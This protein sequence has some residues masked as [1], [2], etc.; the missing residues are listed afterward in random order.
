LVEALVLLRQ[1]L[2]DEAGATEPGR[3]V[4]PGFLRL[5]DELVLGE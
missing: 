5:L 1:Q 2:G 4:D 3:A